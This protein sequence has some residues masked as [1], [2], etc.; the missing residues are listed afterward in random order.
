MKS[1]IRGEEGSLKL[2]L[3]DEVEGEGGVHEDV[4]VPF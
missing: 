3:L 2:N 4:D 1:A